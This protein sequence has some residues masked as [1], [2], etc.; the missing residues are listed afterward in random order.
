MITQYSRR[1][2]L[3]LLVTNEAQTFWILEVLLSN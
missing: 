1:S 2:I 3:L